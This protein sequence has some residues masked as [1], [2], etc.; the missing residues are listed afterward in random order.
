MPQAFR[1]D[2]VEALNPVRINGRSTAMINNIFD[3]KFSSNGYTYSY[4]AGDIVTEN[5][6]YPQAGFNFM[7]GLNVEF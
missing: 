7:L 1:Q 3:A 6:V 2:T 5:F 4:L